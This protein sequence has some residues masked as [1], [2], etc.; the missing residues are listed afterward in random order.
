MP[1]NLIT[2]EK[3]D[4]QSFTTLVEIHTSK[5]FSLLLAT[6]WKHNAHKQLII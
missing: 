6:R 2:V 3:L 4:F 5:V 1:L